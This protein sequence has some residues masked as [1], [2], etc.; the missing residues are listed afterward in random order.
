MSSNPG[1]VAPNQEFPDGHRPLPAHPS[2]EF[3]R[4]RAKNLLREMRRANPATELADAQFAL[5]QE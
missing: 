1:A 4:K 3:E 5:A 2:L